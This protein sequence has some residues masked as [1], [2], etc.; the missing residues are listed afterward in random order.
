MSEAERD[1]LIGAVE[2]LRRDDANMLVGLA[3]MAQ[4]MRNAGFAPSLKAH[5]SLPTARV[6]PSYSE[7]CVPTTAGRGCEGGI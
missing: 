2:V 1:R 7:G 3:Y 5:S 6:R 4:S